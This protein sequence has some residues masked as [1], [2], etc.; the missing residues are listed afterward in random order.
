MSN[1]QTFNDAARELSEA[2]QALCWHVLRAFILPPIKLI[3]AIAEEIGNYLD[4]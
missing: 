2:W 4:D 1:K 3:T